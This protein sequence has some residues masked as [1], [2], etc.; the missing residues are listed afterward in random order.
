MASST[1]LV[2]ATDEMRLDNAAKSA[3]FRLGHAFGF[4]ADYQCVDYLDSKSIS[5]IFRSLLHDEFQS[6]TKESLS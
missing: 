4:K 3:P 1:T 6:F 2:M 5:A